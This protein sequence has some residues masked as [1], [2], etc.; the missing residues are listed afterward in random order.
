MT[1]IYILLC[2][3]STTISVLINQLWVFVCYLKGSK[4]LYLSCS[5]WHLLFCTDSQLPL[6]K[7]CFRA[8]SL[9]CICCPPSH[10]TS[11]LKGVLKGWG[12]GVT[13][14]SISAGGKGSSRK[15]RCGLRT[16]TIQFY[17]CIM[18]SKLLWSLWQLVMFTSSMRVYSA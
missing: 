7:C 4:Y 6:L 1:S 8:L 9:T 12:L 16:E 10:V 3:I 14:L 18:A 17:G 11:G 5:C 13:P 15:Q 2:L